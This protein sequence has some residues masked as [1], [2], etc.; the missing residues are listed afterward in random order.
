M[1][2]QATMKVPSL[3][4]LSQH[5]TPKEQINKVIGIGG[6]RVTRRGYSEEGE[7]H[8]GQKRGSGEGDSFADPPDGHE[9]NNRHHPTDDDGHSWDGKESEQKKKHGSRD[10]SDSLAVIIRAVSL[11]T[12][13]ISSV[14]R[15]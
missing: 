13:D 7:K 14:E 15:Q 1:E 11:F 8:Q 5:E 2:R 4:G 10:E 3:H 9:G 6:C 12:H